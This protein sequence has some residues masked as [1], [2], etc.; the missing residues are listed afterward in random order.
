MLQDILDVKLHWNS[1][2][3]QLILDLFTLIGNCFSLCSHTEYYPI[4]SLRAHNFVSEVL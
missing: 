1:N 2:W 3:Y 4:T